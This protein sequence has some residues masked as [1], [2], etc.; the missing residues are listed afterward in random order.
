MSDFLDKLNVL[1][2]AN[3]RN[4]L[5]GG[6]ERLPPL[7]ETL[8]PDK[9]GKDVDREIAAL[10][11]QVEIALSEEDRLKARLEALYAENAD[12]DTKADAA[13][14]RG[15][16]AGARQIVSAIQR[17]RAK[18][19]QW[20][21]ELERH[22]GATFDLIQHVNTLESLVSDARREQAERAAEHGESAHSQPPASTAPL[23]DAT[24]SPH[25][26]D[27][28]SND[29]HDS[30]SSPPRPAFPAILSD[31]LKN[32]REKVEEFITPIRVETQA[33]PPHEGESHP[34][35]A[36][37]VDTSGTPKIVQKIPVTGGEGSPDKAA[38]IPVKTTTS[39]PPSDPAR[40]PDVDADLARRRSRLSK[41]E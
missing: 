38:P 26:H 33:Q 14:E 19:R 16:D 35:D 21:A 15:D 36:P 27:T 41:P 1:L 6:T 9:L 28:P 20:E 39:P 11:K 8:T 2:Q 23:E 10:R 13:L 34:A 24:H 37:K 29:S 22:R 4:F 3:L 18:G 5:G 25:S 12:L 7:P 17:G 32:V 31:V 30:H 40:D